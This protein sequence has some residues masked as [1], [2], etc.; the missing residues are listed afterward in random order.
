MARTATGVALAILLVMAGC[1]GGGN[2]NPT[3]TA[4][5]TTPTATESPVQTTTDIPTTTVET[6]TGEHPFVEG[7]TLNT[8][9]LLANHLRSLV[10]SESYTVIDAITGSDPASDAVEV[11]DRLRFAANGSQERSNGTW[12]TAQSWRTPEQP[13]DSYRNDSALCVHQ[14]ESIECYDQPFTDHTY[15]QFGRDMFFLGTVRTLRFLE[16]EPDGVV[17]RNGQQFYRYTATGFASNLPDNGFSEQLSN[18]QFVSATVLVAP[19]G[20]IYEY[21]VTIR[22]ETAD[23]PL[24]VERTHQVLA[25]NKTIVET[26][27][28]LTG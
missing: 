22:G 1:A 5:S 17:T 13:E 2:G 4:T 28:W 7:G 12:I 15:R 16:V 26:P 10:Y 6:V 19:E 20:Y 27:E 11:E 18:E 21:S 23:G 8:T 25:M 9:L 14:S 3:T 24:R